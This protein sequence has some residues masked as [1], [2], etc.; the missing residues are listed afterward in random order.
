MKKLI[1]KTALVTRGAGFLGSHLCDALIKKGFRVWCVDNLVTGSKNNIINL[2]GKE[3]FDFLEHDTTKPFS[4]KETKNL[5]NLDYIF[6]LASPASPVDYELLPEETALVN[7]V[8]ITNM[9]KLA[10]KTKARFLQASTS[11]VYGDPLEHP[12]KETYWGNVNSFGARSC[13]KE[14]KR[15]AETMV[16]IY[17]HKYKVNARL[18]RIFNTYGP[19]MRK[20]D[21]RVIS[22][23]LNQAYDGKP[24]TVYGNGSQTRSFCF[25]SDLVDGICK[26]MFSN[27][28]KGEIF[29]LG[30]PDE[31]TILEIAEKIKRL[32]GS[33]S[34]ITLNP[35]PDD[36][37]MRRKPDITKAK[38]ILGWEPKIALEEGLKATIEYYKSS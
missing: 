38:K 15:F 25:V 5:K 8:G 28:T 33:K 29:N 27:N 3:Y 23:F 34:K 31:Y 7:S 17:L 1:K 11:E 12:Q 35:L 14:S 32:V 6:N 2:I 21:G 16:Y 10:I 26:A 13:Y 37:C 9:L 19:R 36:E 22:N 30:N 18:I 4:D 20:N 24:I